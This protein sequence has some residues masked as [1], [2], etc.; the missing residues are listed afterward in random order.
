MDP[1]ARISIASQRTVDDP[2]YSGAVNLR[3]FPI[4]YRQ[5]REDMLSREVVEGILRILTLSLVVISI[6]S[7]LLYMNSDGDS[8]PY[9]SVVMLGIQ[10]LGYSLPLIIGAEAVFKKI[11]SRKSVDLS[12]YSL[13]KSQW[14][15]DI[16]YVVKFLVLV[17]F[18]LTL[19]IIQGVKKSRSKS[20][21]R[22]PREKPILIASL[23]IHII[24]F[25][26]V[27]I[28]QAMRSSLNSGLLQREGY[29]STSPAY[30]VWEV[31]LKEY[32]GLV[33]D[34]FLLPQ[35]IGNFIWQIDERP[36]RKTY[37]IGLTVVRLLP[38]LYDYVTTSLSNPYMNAVHE[39]V[40]PSADFF[41][42]FGDVAIPLTMAL[43]VAMVSV[44][45]RWSYERLSTELR[46]GKF[47][48][49]PS[50]SRAYLRLTSKSAEAELVS[51]MRYFRVM[52][53]E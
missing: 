51:G 34:L 25:I 1:T 45:Q 15:D 18:L 41:T 3:T 52:T 36:L 37:Y 9:V 19:R 10:A 27:I 23:A 14:I 43:L 38:H 13:E 33:H 29:V 48:I 20:L 44:Q 7:Q 31:K 42:R 8:A 17:G 49:L 30:L 24:G 50:Y 28:I 46:F 21:D 12:T 32:V 4:M 35:V 6:F 16:D 40:D 11:S 47:G 39:F 26:I 2:L 53:T 5:Q 22:A